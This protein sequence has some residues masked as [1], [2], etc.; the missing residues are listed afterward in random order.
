[1]IDGNM[2]PV[3]FARAVIGASPTRSKYSRSSN[4]HNRPAISDLIRTCAMTSCA[5]GRSMDAGRL[6]K[7]EDRLYCDRVGDAPMTALAKGLR[8]IKD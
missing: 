4:F 1:M 8:A 3:T 6:W 2:Q 5:F 7:C